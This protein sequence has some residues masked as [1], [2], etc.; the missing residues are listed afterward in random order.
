[1]LALIVRRCV[2]RSVCGMANESFDS[3]VTGKG[4]N[5]GS[6]KSEVW[7]RI[8]NLNENVHSIVLSS[9][10]SNNGKEGGHCKP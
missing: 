5:W 6:A 10:L 4:N 8:N 1:M 2:D 7:M 3:L 9:K